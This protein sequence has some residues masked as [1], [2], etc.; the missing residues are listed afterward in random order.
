MNKSKS[1]L[2]VLSL[3]VMAPA[4]GATEL[5][6]ESDAQCKL[7]ERILLTMMAESESVRA[8]P[9]AHELLGDVYAAE[10]FSVQAK[11]EYEISRVLAKR[12]TIEGE[13]ATEA[14]DAL[15]Q[16]FARVTEKSR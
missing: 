15:K 12:R 7:A 13:A 14:A 3:T 9:A 11:C 5:T 16:L 1:L 10:G 6:N 8:E 2:V 4:A